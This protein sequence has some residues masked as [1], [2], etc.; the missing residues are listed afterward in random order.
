L[1]LRVEK[2]KRRILKTVVTKS[3]GT[4]VHVCYGVLA[5]ILHQEWLFTIIFLFKQFLDVYNGENPAVT[6]GD[7]ASYALGLIIGLM[8]MKVI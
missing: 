2:L 4:I 1:K 7:I 3:F 8:V 5:G 6:S